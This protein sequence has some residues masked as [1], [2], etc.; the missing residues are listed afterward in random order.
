MQMRNFEGGFCSWRTM[1]S[2]PGSS[3]SQ[4]GGYMCQLVGGITFQKLHIFPQH[5]LW[6]WGEK[7]GIC[8]PLA[9]PVQLHGL[10]GKNTF[11]STMHLAS[12]KGKIWTP[13]VLCCQDLV[14]DIV[15]DAVS[16][17]KAGIYF[18]I[19]KIS[20]IWAPYVQLQMSTQMVSSW[21]IH[22][23]KETPKKTL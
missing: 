12:N 14:Q 22:G 1:L 4:L 17:V 3:V 21:K 10:I 2:V 13:C 8:C 7:H 16:W 18:I 11:L 5:T 19:L 6:K 23:N 9:G 15:F 20:F